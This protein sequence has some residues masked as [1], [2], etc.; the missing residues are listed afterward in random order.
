VAEFVGGGGQ[1]LGQFIECG[2]KGSFVGD[3]IKG[4][5]QDLQD[6]SGLTGLS[7]SF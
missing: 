5:G 3:I 1:A 2:H 7:Y 4:N 6:C